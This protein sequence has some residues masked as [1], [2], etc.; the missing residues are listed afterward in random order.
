M[1]PPQ[2]SVGLGPERMHA[3]HLG[4]EAVSEQSSKNSTEPSTPE[5]IARPWEPPEPAAASPMRT[6]A[7]PIA[8]SPDRSLS[9][10]FVT[11]LG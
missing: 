10:D 6:H 3:C 5:G 8:L 7:N 1:C 4:V 11:K 9:C 2:D